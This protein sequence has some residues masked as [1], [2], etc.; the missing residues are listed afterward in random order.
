MKIEEVIQKIKNYYRGIDSSGLKIDDLKSRDQ[1]LY[2]NI[3][4]ECTGIVT[5]C[6]A[7]VDVIREAI[8]K[9]ANLIISHE[10]LFWN[11]GDKQDWLKK[12]S[13][14]QAKTRLL[15]K[16][17]IAVWR[18][19]DYIHSGIPLDD[20]YVDGIFYG[21]I[22]ALGWEQYLSA[23]HRS[24]LHFDFDGIS[25]QKIAKDL[26]KGLH[27]EGIRLIGD[28]DAIIDKLQVIGHIMGPD[29]PVITDIE[30]NDFDAVIALE[31]IDYTVSEY[32][33]DAAQLGFNKVIF[34]PGHFNFEEE[35]M[36]YMLEYLPDILGSDIPYYYAKS[37]DTFHYL[38]K[39]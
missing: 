15:D 26:I 31:L 3:D 24:L 4:Q 13:V 16:H 32:I 20:E 30:E 29:N 22:K 17:N 34:A 11:R 28:P 5:T 14:Y 8:D 6:F 19:H 2:G 18:N 9:G 36:A 12:N 37:G 25:A 7:S 27:L 39:E 35:G 21:V 23:D 38:L 1:V 10:A 33:R